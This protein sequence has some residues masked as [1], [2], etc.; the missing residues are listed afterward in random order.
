M[1]FVHAI[2]AA[3][4]RSNDYTWHA[5]DSKGLDN[6]ADFGDFSEI[7][8]PGVLANCEQCHLPNTYNFGATASADA[9]G[10]G[11]DG[12]EKRLWRTV[13]TGFYSGMAGATVR[14]FSG[15][16][17]LTFGTSSATKN[18]DVFTQPKAY[19]L[20]QDASGNAA[21]PNTGTYYGDGFRYNAGIAASNAACTANGTVVP[22][23]PA[24]GII[25]AT[26]E[27]LVMSATVAVCTGCHDSNL[28]ISHMRVNGGSFYES[29]AIASGKDRAVHG[30]PRGWQDGR[31]QGGARRQVA[32]G[33]NAVA[34]GT[35]PAATTPDP[36]VATRPGFFLS[37]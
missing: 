30:L 6:P 29:R 10:I 7:G 36:A 33:S 2:H 13:A 9:A 17:C 15:A 3:A 18:I 16:D 22:A 11:A 23:N 14:T 19:G 27:T 35:F 25:Q 34:A 8:Y 32:H 24:Q 5:V 28:A 37:S 4:K 20:M 21:T 12:I 26:P 31:H 1:A